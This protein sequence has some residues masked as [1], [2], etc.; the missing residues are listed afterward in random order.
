MPIPEWLQKLSNATVKASIAENPYITAV[1]GWNIDSRT[2]NIEQTTREVKPKSEEYN[3]TR[4]EIMS[5]YSGGIKNLLDLL[6]T[7]SSPVKVVITKWDLY[8][9]VEKLSGRVKENFD[10]SSRRTNYTGIGKYTSAEIDD[11]RGSLHVPEYS[12][13]FKNDF[14]S[15][16]FN[17]NTPLEENHTVKI[18][19]NQDVYTKILPTYD[20]SNG[21]RGYLL[22][23]ENLSNANELD[24]LV[25]NNNYKQVKRGYDAKYQK[26][27]DLGD[28]KHFYDAGTHQYV[29][30][31]KDGKQY[32]KLVDLFDVKGNNEKWPLKSYT[33][34]IA[35]YE[36]PYIVATPWKEGSRSYNV[37]GKI[38][39]IFNPQ[40]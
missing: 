24:D 10:K 18:I 35:K 12:E 34:F 38:K 13:K 22:K 32:Y 1:S 17:Y 5:R 33:E 4:A 23:G 29:E 21:F 11:F 2:G 7:K 30:V 26:D 3:R 31:E 39:S 8:P 20:T 27:W 36:K 9:G 15:S 6:V 14:V 16:L 25:R 37:G 28:G 19:E 40:Q